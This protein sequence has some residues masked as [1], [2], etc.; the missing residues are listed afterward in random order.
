MVA[1][2]RCAVVI[3]IE[4]D[5][6][7]VESIYEPSILLHSVKSGV[8]RATMVIPL[9]SGRSP[10]AHSPW[11]RAA[12]SRKSLHSPGFLAHPSSQ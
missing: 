5:E 12:I 3:E 9:D 2:I 8:K 6:P 10:A 4:G 1:R 11:R 7:L